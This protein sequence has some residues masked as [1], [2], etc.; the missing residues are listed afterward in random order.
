GIIRRG[1]AQRRLHA[2]LREHAEHLIADRRRGGGGVL[3]IKRHDQNAV[4]AGGLHGGKARSD[5]R[6]AVAH[7]PVDRQVAIWQ[8]FGQFLRLRARDGLQRRLVALLVPDF[9]VVAA[10]AGG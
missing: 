6:V 7:R 1:D 8:R 3:W 10:L 2:H 5:R 4:A 9:V